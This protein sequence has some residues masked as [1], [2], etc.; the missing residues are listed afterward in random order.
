[1]TRKRSH[2]NSGAISPFCFCGHQSNTRRLHI[3]PSNKLQY[4][5]S[6]RTR[7][8]NLAPNSNIKSHSPNKMMMC[9]LLVLD[10]VTSTPQWIRQ[11]W[12][13]VY[14]KE[15]TYHTRLFRGPSTNDMKSRMV[16]AAPGPLLT[17]PP[18]SPPPKTPFRSY[19]AQTRSQ[20]EE[21]NPPP[22]T[23]PAPTAK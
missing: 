21:K 3:M 5:K 17:P 22:Q 16:L 4:P 9:C 19:S 2:N 7:S 8:Q 11:P 10:S 23:R 12:K 14:L 6:Q 18:S 20:N 15:G 1:M 13:R